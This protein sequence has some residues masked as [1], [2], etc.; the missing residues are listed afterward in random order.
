[1]LHDEKKVTP[2]LSLLPLEKE[3]IT[4]F[5]APFYFCYSYEIMTEASGKL[6]K[7]PLCWTQ[8]REE[9]FSMM[10]QKFKEKER[11]VLYEN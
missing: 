3:R 11:S 5:G 4:A 2:I 10:D 7:T 1:M 9:N 8:A 6:T